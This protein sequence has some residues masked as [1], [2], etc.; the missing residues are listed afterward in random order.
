MSSSMTTILASA[1]VRFEQLIVVIIISTCS[2]LDDRST[3]STINK[4]AELIETMMKGFRQPARL[5]FFT[6]AGARREGFR[7]YILGAGGA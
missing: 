6:R 2:V 4:F 5:H 3:I 7:P 1:N